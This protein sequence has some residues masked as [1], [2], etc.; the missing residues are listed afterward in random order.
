MI[1]RGQRRLTVIFSLVLLC[2]SLLLVLGGILFFNDILLSAQY[3]HLR[4]EIDVELRPAYLNEDTFDVDLVAHT[5]L[6]HLLNRRGDV[7]GATLNSR[8]FSP[9]L[10]PEALEQAFAGETVFRRIGVQNREYLVA[11]FHLDVYFSGRAAVDLEM[12]LK[13]QRRFLM[14][15]LVALPLVGLVAVLVSWI[16]VRQAMRPI[17]DTFALQETFAENAAHELMSPLTALKG[18]LEVTLRRDHT[19]E[20]YREALRANL[21]EVLRLSD[22]LNRLRLL[23]RSGFEPES[24][25]LEAVTLY[26]LVGR[27]YSE[28]RRAVS[29]PPALRFHLT[30]DETVS[31]LADPALLSQLLGNLLD[32]ALK[33]T[34]PG[35]EI[36][37]TVR[38]RWRRV[39][40]TLENDCEDLGVARLETLFAPFFR[41]ANRV[42]PGGTGGADRASGGEPPTQGRHASLHRIPGRGLG[43][44]LARNFAHA[45]QG[46]L[47][48]SLPRPGRF[49]IV[50]RLPRA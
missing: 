50:L 12:T 36:T 29:N 3:Q 17:A 44:A 40:L 47:E 37:C 18:T 30:G 25:P 23:A 6:F 5:V 16:L 11:Y 4:E 9:P 43:L 19:P 33:Y 24:L 27:L 49:R 39:L 13:Q 15:V 38:R 31:V 7:V 48:A 14:A 21:D 42:R 45:H 32:N 28:R 35:R 22:V 10:D 20:G 46:T 8:D 41:G 26:P 1:D 34:P 2:F